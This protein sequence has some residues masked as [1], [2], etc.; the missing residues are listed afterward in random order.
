MKQ[1]DKLDKNNIEN[2]MSLT[3][4]QQGM[5]FHYVNDEN[6]SMYHEQLSLTIKGDVKL[7]LLHEA[8]KIVIENNEMLRTIFRWK[9]INEP[10][11]VVLK[12][13]QITIKYIDITNVCDKEMSIKE[14]KSNDLKNRID[15]TRE[16]LRIYLCKLDENLYEMIISN[17]HIL[18][19]GWS[20]GIILTELMEAYNYLYANKEPKKHIKTKFNQFIKY[21]NS[22]DK[23]KE[24]EYWSNYLDNLTSIDDC[25]SCKEKGTHKEITYKIDSIKTNKIKDFSKENKILLSSILYSAWGILLSKLNNTND[26]LFGITV[27]GRPENI[28]LIDK[29]VGLFISTIPLRVKIDEETTLIELINVIDRSLTDR[30]GFENTSL[31][32]VKDYCGLKANE[33]LF[34]SIVAIENYPLN[35]SEN[36][37]NILFAK[38]FSI[39][40]QTNYNMSLEIL[41][42]DGIEFKFKF[43]DLS[44]DEY[45]VNKL[46]V[47]L[48]RIIE[49]LMSDINIRIRNIKL[50]SK[51]EEK[52]ILEE[53]NNT[54]A[55]YPKDKTIHELFEEQVEKTPD[56]IAV[57]F[58]D[59]KM[60]YKEL[61]E[62]SNSLA[63]VLR[64]KGVKADSIVGIMV[65]RSIEMI[66]GIMGILKAGGAYLPIDPS[67][68]KERVEYM[69]K[70]SETRILLSQEFLVEN[71]EFEG[72]VIDLYN[73]DLYKNYTSNLGKINTSKSLAYVI[74][75]SGS[76]GNPK[77]VMIEN[78]N[79]IN[80]INCFIKQFDKKFDLNDRVLSLT[81][82][83]FDVSI[84]EFFVALL[85]GAKLVINNKHKTFEYKEISELI[86]S[87]KI[88]FTY[89]PPSL[90]P[91]VY[92]ELKNCKKQIELRKLLVGVEAIKGEVL[93][94]YYNL[95]EDIEIINGYGPTES[96]ICATFYK[97]NQNEEKN[98]AVP[99]GKVVENTQIYILDNY[100]KPVPIGVKGEIFVSGVA[101][102]RGY[103][104]KE[105]LTK[106]KFVYNPFDQGTKMY[107]TGDL[108]RWLP[109]GNIEFLG[110][111]DNQVK[112]RGFRIELGEIENRILQHEKIKEAAVLVKENKNSEKSICAYIVSENSLEELKLKNYLKEI[113]PEYMIP[114]YFVQLEKMPLTPNGKFDRKALQEPNMELILS[115][116][117]APRN[118]VE[119]I[120]SKIWSEVLGVEKIGINDNFFELGGHSL[121]ATMLMSK[122]QKEL[123]KEVPLKE[124]FKTPTIK[125][126]F[127][128]IEKAE[129]NLYSKIEEVEEK[130]Y[131]EASSAQKRM[132]ILQ[133]FDKESIAYNMPAIFEIE[134]KIDKSKIEET[135]RKL[136]QRHDAL[137]TY[138]E[139][140]D[141]EIV[142]KLQENYE[143]KLEQRNG[144]IED[145]LKAFVRPFELEKAPLFRIE[146]LEDKEKVHLLVDMHH[147]ISDGVSMSI[148]INEFAQLYN[149]KK[150][151]DLKLQ[152]KDFA[153][154]QNNFLK[155]EEM[156]K[157]EEY[158]VNKFSDEIPVL[159]MP[160]DYN[161]PAVQSFEGDSVGFEVNEEITS[162]L[163]KLA[164][165][166]G[167][168]MYMVLLSV[169]NILLSKYSGQEDIVIGT[170]IAG[171]PH[172]DL[173]NIMGM[174]V[175]TLAL[176]N[177]PEGE[178][179]YIDFLKEV[180]ENSLKAYENQSYQFEELIEKLDVRRD[181]SRNP[182]FDV[183]FNIV[184]TITR[185]DV[186]LEDIILK[187]YNTGNI[188]SKFD[189]T[190]NAIE[191]EDK[192]YFSIEYCTKLFKKETIERISKH[193]IKVIDNI[194]INNEIKLYEI[195][196]LSKEDKKQ[197]L[198]EF[199]NTKAEYPKNKT[200]HG[201]FEE[202][203]ERTPDNIAV[204][205]EDKKLT[206]KELNEKSNSLARVLR[207]KGVKEE[208]IVGIMTEKSTEM[209]IGIMGILKAGGAY[210]PI[211]PNY[212]EQR[213]SYIIE[214]SQ[215]NIILTQNFLINKID[216]KA[217]FI[218]L[219][220][221]ELYLRK[222]NNLERINS[223][224]NLAYV[225]YTSGTTNN[226]KGV[227]VEHQ[228]IVNTLLW[229]RKKYN[230]NANDVTLQVPSFS[231]DSSVEDIF[232]NL[233]SGSSLLLVSQ[234]DKTDL[235]NLSEI[236]KNNN[237][238]HFLI[239]PSLYNIYLNE[240][241]DKLEG[242]TRITVAGESITEALVI[243]HF[244]LLP[245]VELYNEYGPT[246]NSVCSTI[247]E[248]SADTKNILI[249]KPI[250]NVK[251]YI[252]N[253]NY[254][255]VPIGVIG[256][257]YISGAGLT[258]GYL[259]RAELTEE[260]FVDNLFESGTKMY[261][262]GDLARWMPD[263]SIEFLGR[264]DNQVKIRGYRIELAEIENR[265]LQHEKIKEAISVVKESMENEKYICAYIVSENSLEELKLKNYLKE[266]LPEYMIPS[267]FIQLEKMP[268]TPNGKLDR[269]ALPEPNMK[270]ILSE[271]E[272]PRNEVEETLTKIWSEVLGVEKI[273][274]NDNFFDIGGH[275]LK[276][277]ML[278]YKIHKKLNK[279]IPLKEIF[280]IPTIKEL[281]K[282]IEN[283]EENLYSNI[284]K[285]E[286][287]EHYEASSAQKRMY[288]L[289][290]FDKDSIAYNMPSVFELEGK[291][292]KN[293]IEETFRKLT[294]R[295]E[296]LRTYFETI[297]G[298]IVQKIQSDYEFKLEQRDENIEKAV[299]SFIRPF[300]L[301]KA[302]LFRIELL[303]DKEKVYLLVD[304]HHIISDGVSMSIIINEFAQLYNGKKLED[305]KLQYKDFAVWQNNFLK[306][307]EMKKQEEYW[308]NKFS[309]EIPVLNMPTDYNRPAVQS[310]EGDSVGFEVNEEITSKLRKLAKKTGTTMY[311]V[312][313]SVFNILLSKYSGQE[314]IVIGTP[315]AG[316]PHADLQNIMGMFVN[317]LALRNKP[318]GEK[319]YIDFLKEVKENSLKAYENQSYQLETLVEKLDVRRDTSRNPLFDVMF[320]I[321][322]TLNNKDVK[323]EDII[324]KPYN[325]GSQISKFDMI[326]NAMEKD[327]KLY[328]SIEYCTKLFK[329]ETMER[330]SEHCI[331][332]LDSI[333]NNKEIKL[334]EIDLL[335]ETEKNQILKEFNNT[336]VEYPKDKTIHDL[337]EEQVEKIPDNVAVVFEDKQ[338]TYRELNERS[339][340]L[341]R[342]LRDKGIKA[343]SIVGIMVERS[344]E[345]TI[346]IM[347]IIKAGG[348]YLPIDPT[349]PKERIEYI[350]K[351]SGSKILLSQ[352]SLVGNVEFDGI[353]IDLY[354]EELYANNTNNLDKIN[355]SN[356]LAYI[357]YTSGT[358]GNPKGVMC[359][360]KN[361]VRLV[362]NTNYI[363]FKADDKILQTGS[364]VFDASTFE[365]WG[366]FL[367]G[368]ELYLAKNETIMLAESLERFVTNNNITI[369]WLTSELFN[370]LAEEDINIF[371]ELRYLLVGG[372]VLSPKYINLVRGQFTKLKIINGYGPTENTTFSTT[373]LIEKYNHNIPIGKPIANSQAYIIDRNNILNPIGIYG[374]LCVSGD[375]LARGYLNK[376]EL[377]KEK[378]VYNPFEP[379]TKMYKTGDLARWLPDGNIEFLGRIDNQVKIRG[380]RIELGEIENRILQHENIKEAVVVVKE[381]EENEKYICAYVV[382]ENSIEELN[383][384]IYLKE[385]LPEY[386]I[387]TYF[388]Q[389]E[390]MPLTPNG[391]LD[392]KAFPEP[393]IN[394]N[395]TEYEAPRNEVE[396]TLAKIWSEVLGVEKIGIN[397]NFF[398]L[399]GHSLKATILMSRMHKELNK[400]VPLKE[401]FKTPTIKE[402]SKF[403]EIAEENIYSN[404][405]KVEEKEYYEA[406]SSQKRMYILQ[407]FDKDSIAYNMPVVFELEGEI[408]K[409]KIEDTFRELSKR[410]EALRT[411]FKTMDG[412]IVQK[413]QNDYGFKLE[414]RDG[415]IENAV[416]SFIKPFEL[417]KAPLFRVELVESEEKN[418]LLV[419]M[420]HIISDGVS[421]SII[422]NE[423]AQ[424]YNGKKLED[425]K[426]QYKDFAV[427]QNNFLKSEEMKKQEEYWVNKFSDEIPVLNMPTDYNRPAVQS[428]EGDSVGF[429]VNEE[430]TSKLRKLAKKTGT[431]MYMVLL[432]VFNILLS[433][434]S[435]QEDIVIGTPI[436]GRPHADLQNIM[437]M[438][439]NTLA[440]RNKPEGE[441]KYIDFLKEVK[442][443]SLKAYENQ[444]YQLET[445][446]E[447][448]DVRRDTSRNPLFDVM[449]NIVDTLNNKDVK[450]EDIILK[451][452]NTGSQISKFDMTLNAM[453]NGDKLYFSIEYCTKLFKKETIE[454]LS[455]HCIKILDSIVNNKEI[456]LCEIDLLSEQEKKQILEEFNDTKAD[457]P[458]DKTIYELFEEQVEKTPDNI[459]V[460]SEDKKLT[461]R[462]LN[463]K[464]NSI[465]KVLREKGVK[466]DSIAGIMVE[467]SLEMMIGIMGILKAG[468]AYLPIDPTYPKERIEYM[469]KDSGSKIL[470]SQNTLVENVE[471][472]GIVIDLYNNELYKNNS[473]NLDKINTSNNL[474]YV[475]YTSGT[476]GNPK[477]AMIEHSALV[478]RL[479]WMQNKYLLNE[480]DAILQKTTYTF[481]VSVWELLWWSLVGAKV[482]MLSPNDEKDPAKIIDAINRN[483]ITTMHFVP[484]M[485]DTFLYFL[486]KSNN[487][488]SLNSLKQVFC[489]GEAL[490]FKHVL[491]FY[492][493]FGNSKKLINLYG[494][495]EAAIDV[496]YFDINSDL[497]LEVIPIGKPI[498]NIKLYILDAYKKMQPVGILGELYISGD[499]LA[500][501]YLNKLELT[502]EKFVD[503]PFE[504]GT[505]MYKTG[506]IARWLPDGNVEYLGRI[507]NQVK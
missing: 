12:K 89:I 313:L 258:R 38:S 480:K 453:E 144:N 440:L 299:K 236:I 506:D 382:S 214:D 356:D 387:P 320:N 200:I 437:G 120:L 417:E 187:P 487:D 277:T 160:T 241:G 393:N 372:D 410:H 256:E 345:M 156:K 164:K 367:N 221:E 459:A 10:I 182:L 213:I 11:Q 133:Q 84:C 281:S 49:C 130:E 446:V 373:Y 364:M 280:K 138:F 109:D 292:D 216:H 168:T 467:R 300:E 470:L 286:E 354:N 415:N 412:E 47:Y 68:P 6:S 294:K 296:S 448:L 305:L 19:D 301:E 29:M 55:E 484:S 193:C 180:K 346:G 230:F 21:L 239:V 178:K 408:D 33:E 396:E 498:N 402:L 142:Q 27:S 13:H 97:I 291:I 39:I 25:F 500:R 486:D 353:V 149:G 118:E 306:S 385:I 45:I 379:G 124:I 18:Y 452:Y 391:K 383:L 478:N 268:H 192:L 189:M 72:M 58:E 112:V 425:L 218:N 237:V 376:L 259:N 420:H 303:E 191:T 462:E 493:E 419:D 203:A 51:K 143:L 108:A 357:I 196:L 179:K 240:I 433:K 328:F 485:L 183:M 170:P 370:Q 388:V 135:F 35:I 76:T 326:L 121:K 362:K 494:P 98:K 318:E 395:I 329:K 337:F 349:Y 338:L 28:S 507:D 355:N 455:K 394:L 279:E 457:Y 262:T 465:A 476:T 350:L 271:Y 375:G 361:V 405:E 426:L 59:K 50:L 155:S 263:G 2:F 173:Q 113:L 148:I 154:W 472:D 139:T 439:V 231:F 252:L 228:S 475:I 151:E 75:T 431:T 273:G 377:T 177:K 41:T 44:I 288:I 348:V 141:G 172:A 310:F 264:V 390:K 245:N 134:G 23:E 384:K 234:K 423:F 416:K 186:K 56:N 261:K 111:M 266:T 445:L 325:T 40:E 116:Y 208:T 93:N 14:V 315:I 499:G 190:L 400:E 145:I 210:L 501:G 282:Y 105:E 332:V 351:D 466:A 341:A 126:I 242:L 443:N 22:I 314:D 166:T 46:G 17:H 8:W 26:V 285:V 176:R 86:I 428:F 132:Y 147:I 232:T 219:N 429:E 209:M 247:Y 331:K 254:K 447:K 77:G 255:L 127:K 85:N 422:I 181:T 380:F 80:F 442:E 246:E 324:L 83:A 427:W 78:T 195:E 505:K 360:H 52:Q 344:L 238:T 91:S 469:L 378:F 436:A 492:K 137:R 95:N 146:L 60:T 92:E 185:E 249:G 30:K 270:L 31:I 257:L 244:Q 504:T 100:L 61:N 483:K 371:K 157:Q 243:K 4:L 458:K 114:S 175:N 224:K 24:K 102:A 339:N 167:T 386:M 430:I 99:I 489:S 101:I 336:K 174:F 107:K 298:E 502:K 48:E 398:E 374:E 358:T 327:D 5:L 481:D 225:I 136:T 434:Y 468:G 276:A 311:M 482:C 115:D 229:R 122:I 464:S 63:R 128:Y 474:A 406:S 205:F 104:N 421:M 456:K 220:D 79:L 323:L 352:N 226:P 366:A 248:F 119:E 43:N 212:P 66:I 204:V 69:L 125:E 250:D 64:E 163:R 57:V 454:R 123:N 207:E 295:H 71:I 407:Q 251:C 397:D 20:N 297:K 74:Y 162:K 496:S 198:E 34:N 1:D 253:K 497:D 309:D 275:S 9:G 197:I 90:L 290:Q 36:K 451:P 287:K 184:D 54:E 161:R 274:I 284:E 15:I 369:L 153:V 463:E 342:V 269:K 411:Y 88:T 265:I 53:F 404:I 202:Q 409:N 488:L 171:R 150:L 32:D 503:N 217:E 42:F 188:I 235:K 272:A 471:Y 70:D 96:T 302:P 165:K 267:Y 81:N 347:G 169:F 333:M 73:E 424:L 334:C 211:D 363:E 418:Y 87:N 450:L 62:K 491:R 389:L 307:E 368:L 340:S 304:M 194:V 359:E 432:S 215:I 227:T 94:E 65:E 106:E 399:G 293:K 158:W 140:L 495:T 3:S 414:Q 260:K 343:D 152:Y 222:R 479:L 223:E 322:D 444:S 129:K 312:L 477:G 37:E 308:V 335:S 131:Y 401:I 473:N 392:R 110:R 199:N 16:T 103:L 233:I 289:Q 206:Y 460:V 67:Y 321:V 438:F 317:T 441:K 330:L 413:I 461:Y 365:V 449:F 490:N 403:I 316:R 201:L 278:M 319:K 82:Y 117:E 7:D 159:N 283:A 435:G 381:N